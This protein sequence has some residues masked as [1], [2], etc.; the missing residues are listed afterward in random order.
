MR[1]L[2]GL[3]VLVVLLLLCL[4]L[5]L[6]VRPLAGGAPEPIAKGSTLVVELGG[7]YVE[8]PAASPL[9]RLVGDPTRPFID[10]LKTFLLVERDDRIGTVVL[11]IQPLEIGWGKADELRAAIARVREKGHRTIALLEVQSFSANKELYVG[12]AADE[13]WVAPGASIPLVGMAAEYVFLGGFWQKLGVDFD[14]ARAGKY[15]SA[16][17]IFSERTMSEASR[18]M[19][20]SLLDDTFDRFVEALAEDREKTPDAIRETIDRGYVHARELAEAGLIDGEVHLDE[21]LARIGPDVVEHADYLR[22]DPK[23]VGYDP[24]ARFALVY[25]S[26][27]VVQGDAEPS[28]FAAQPTFASGTVSHAIL[29]AAEDPDIAAIVL[30]IDSPGGS[31]M[32]SELIWRALRQARAKGKPVVASFS[33]VA[34]SGGYYVASG[35]DVIVSDPGTLTGSIGV[36][37]L[38]PVVGGLLEKLEIGVDS[39]TRGAHADFLLSSDKM[40]PE[41]HERLQSSVLETYQLFLARVAEGRALPIERIDGLGQGRVWT[42]RQALD[43]GL[44]D[45]LGGLYVAVRRAKEA[46]GL[47]VAADVELVAFPK[48]KPFTQQ[49]LD[50]VQGVAIRAAAGAGG[51]PIEW[52]EPIGRIVAWTR[53]LPLGT[54]LLI[55]PV[56]IE[57]R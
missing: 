44:V 45:E 41:A 42:G 10:L 14:I 51:P 47:D 40:T 11:R 35:A 15:K 24:R 28:P 2:S 9:A 30:R 26:G 7:A 27:T 8:A 31:A 13:V 12:S 23:L 57:I 22:T 53:D 4:A 16:V 6:F 55:P 50:M 49:L 19:A 1:M 46:V 36:F 18:E 37:A 5:Y 56:M 29:D 3:R 20:N 39:L 32:A 52:P 54:P 38:R 34:A 33:D 17:E 25:G 43:A 21:L 48:Q